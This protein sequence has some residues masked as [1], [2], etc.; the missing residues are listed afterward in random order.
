MRRE[1]W[2]LFSPTTGVV[3]EGVPQDILRTL[4]KR[5]YLI[6]RARNANIVGAPS[7]L[8][9]CVLFPGRC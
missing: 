1:Q 7:P 9:P 8:E 5:T 6:E 2:A 4:R 3:Q